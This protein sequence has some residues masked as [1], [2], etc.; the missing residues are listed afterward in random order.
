MIR[1]TFLTIGLAAALLTTSAAADGPT[2]P[3]PT[4]AGFLLP[5]GWTITPAGKQV[6]LTDLPLNIVPLADGKH[7][8]VATSGFNKHQLSVVDLESLK[9]VD[10]QTVRQSWF[11]L[12]V[13]PEQDRVWWSG[14]GAAMLHTY[15]LK[16]LKLTP[17]SPAEPAPVRPKD[18]ADA[19]K[20]KD[21]DASKPKDEE[22]PKGT[23]FRSGVFL[24]A[25]GRTLYSLDINKATLTAARLDDDKASNVGPVRRPALRRRCSAA[26]APCSTSP[27]GP[28]GPSSPSIRRRLRVI[29]KIP[30]GEHPNQMALH[31]KDDRLF[32]ACAS[33]NTVCVIDTQARRR[34][35]NHPHRRCSRTRRR[36][37]RPTPWP[38]RPTARRSTSP[39]PTTTASPSST[40]PSPDK[41]QVQGFIPTGWYPTAVAVTPDG[42]N[43]LVG[44]GKGNETKP[45]PLFKDKDK[46]RSR[47]D[48]K[49]KLPF[50]Y[51]GTTH[52]RGAVGRAR[53]G[54]EAAG[55]LHRHG[56]PQLSVF[57]QAA[58]RGRAAPANARP[59]RR[60]SATR[61]RSST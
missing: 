53:A 33:S 27:T 5:N 55:R 37:A 10:Q 21:G 32:V 44:V 35:G 49:P 60:R 16:D 47:T 11:G 6:P 23:P 41:S 61:R 3:G 15:D 2:R 28:A 36:A 29:A 38:S 59:S 50:P 45:N 12:A 43:L 13:S 58:R 51:I 46:A 19:P 8:L 34:H 56:V 9:V 4:D 20:P 30:V 14:G 31:P 18:A 39:T 17:T 1:R 24:D 25:K 26:T 48:A 7:A 40:L 52:V 54:R 42:K 57:R 22:P